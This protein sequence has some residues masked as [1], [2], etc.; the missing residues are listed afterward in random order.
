MLVVSDRLIYLLKYWRC[1]TIVRHFL[2]YWNSN[3]RRHYFTFWFLFHKKVEL[4]HEPKDTRNCIFG[5]CRYMAVTFTKN[6]LDFCLSMKILKTTSCWSLHLELL[7]KCRV[8]NLFDKY[9]I[10]ENK[11]FTYIAL[12]RFFLFNGIALLNETMAFPQ[13]RTIVFP[14]LTFS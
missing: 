6:Q 14:Q 4:H 11:V 13:P 5:H 1:I 7:F 10:R 2:F 3:N 12:S 8:I 9:K